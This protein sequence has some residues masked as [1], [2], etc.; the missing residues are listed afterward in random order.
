MISSGGSS[1]NMSMASCASQG[2]GTRSR[3]AAATNCGESVTTVFNLA[4]DCAS[5]GKLDKKKS[6]TQF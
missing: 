2:A 3:L 1:A 4:A 6:V 5:V